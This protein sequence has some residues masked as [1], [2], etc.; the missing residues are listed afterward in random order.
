MFLSVIQAP[1]Y[2]PW[3]G[4]PRTGYGSMHM[5]VRVRL[6]RSALRGT[7]PVGSNSALD[8]YYHPIRHRR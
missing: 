1:A 5:G 4:V 6:K 8:Q 3:S 2:R 7:R